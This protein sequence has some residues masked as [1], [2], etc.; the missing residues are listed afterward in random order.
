M[1]VQNLLVSARHVV[2]AGRIQISSAFEPT[3]KLEVIKHSLVSTIQK[4][5]TLQVTRKVC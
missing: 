1:S 2:V 3:S 4:G 5:Q